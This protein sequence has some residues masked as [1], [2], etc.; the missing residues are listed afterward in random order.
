MR[1][2][3]S[4]LDDIRARL[5]VSAVVGRRVKLVKAG[6]EWKGLSPFNAERTPSF[7]VN[8]QKGFFHCFSSGKHGDIFS[9]V[10][11]TEGL[12]FPE[13]VERLAAE[14]GVELP[15][16]SAESVE[17]EERRRSLHDVLELAAV[18]FEA[19]LKAGAGAEARRYLAGR[20]LD[21]E[22]QRR[23]RL[24]YAPA[25]RFALRDHLA[26]KGVSS[27]LMVDAGLLQSGDDVAVPYDR[28]RDRVMFPIADT[29]G[30]VVAFGGRAL[31][32]DAQ[33]KYLN[34]PETALFHKGALL[35]NHHHARKAAHEA[36]GVVVVEGYVDVI[37]MTRAGLPQVVAPLGT[38]LTEDQLQLVW[39]MAAEPV[40][41]FD[42][43]KAGRRA[44]HRAVDTAL[45][46]LGPGRS[47]RFAFLPDGQDPDD[48]LRTA[49]A[50]ALQ[51]A[52]SRAE[53]LVDVIWSREAERAPLDTPERRAEL[54]RRMRD[55]VA[56]IRDETLRR[57]YRSEIDGRLAA[58]LG[59]V[60]G[61]RRGSDRAGDRRPAFKSPERGQGQGYGQP[62]RPLGERERLRRELPST[63]PALRRSRLF[64]GVPTGPGPREAA[65]I[66]TAVNHP[67]LLDAH[68]ELFAEI[69][70][71]SPELEMLR[72][73]VLAASA[74]EQSPTPETLRAA[75]LRAGL[76]D[77]FSRAETAAGGDFWALAGAALEDV[78]QG[79]HDAADLQMRSCTLNKE[80]RQAERE[81]GETSSAESYGRLRAISG[82]LA[83][84]HSGDEAADAFG[85]ASSKVLAP[86]KAVA[87]GNAVAPGKA[88]APAEGLE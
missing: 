36:G 7:Y 61:H 62:Q 20:D 23:F 35:Y 85:R 32:K 43:D 25:E 27:D 78:L 47:L 67:V 18:F 80:L 77:A 44:A 9:F 68:A 38:A 29:R 60:R 76:G 70:L 88:V 15:R 81:L 16:I 74:E 2:P 19:S 55:L 1:F 3:P 52:V 59:A 26:G 28:F 14:A 71:R 37:A 48:L 64:A 46:L 51:A 79:W 31:Q 8:D 84:A 50:A 63:G 33:A 21:A 4:L 83:V 22:V 24:G 5:P 13:A 87:P 49:G 12:S 6:R 40:L 82:R 17:R 66:V 73:L 53:P 45:P 58:M 10:T 57:H 69:D 86:G 39:R 65:L 34:S 30:R 11:E 72:A 56:S 41:C 75:I 42:G 54:E